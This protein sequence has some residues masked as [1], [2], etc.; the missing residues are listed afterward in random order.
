MYRLIYFGLE[1]FY[2][3]ALCKQFSKGASYKS[4]LYPQSLAVQRMSSLIIFLE[5]YLELVVFLYCTSTE[6]RWASLLWKWLW[7]PRWESTPVSTGVHLPM[8]HCHVAVPLLHDPPV[9]LLRGARE[10]QSQY[11]YTQQTQY[12]T[13]YSVHTTMI[14]REHLVKCVRAVAI[15]IG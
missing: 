2:C 4:Y 1:L 14:L 11:I 3:K 9:L 7:F 5:E 8:M 13:R 15:L 12:N 6:K 10:E